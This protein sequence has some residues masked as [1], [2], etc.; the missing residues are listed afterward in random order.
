MIIQ[1]NILLKNHT[2]YKIGGPARYFIEAKSVAEVQ[3][4]LEFWKEKGIALFVLAGG[5]NILFS[6]GGFAGLVLK[7]SLDSVRLS[8]EE[9]IVEAGAKLSDVVEL[10]AKNGLKG[11]EW[12]G[13]LP[14]TIGGAVFGNAGAFGG[15]MKDI[16]VEVKSLDIRNPEK[17]VSRGN[18]E[19]GFGYRTSAF[20][21]IRNEIILE[22]KLRLQ[23]GDSEEI[24]KAIKEHIRYR[25]ER[26]PLEYPSAGS[27]FKNVDV[28]LVSEEQ[29]K[30]W[31]AV[32][33]TDPF[34]LVPVAHLFSEA[35]LKGKKVGGAMI[36][37]K[38]PNFFINTGGAT[39]SD[40]LDL[41]S[42]AKKTIKE[43][44]GIELEEEVQIIGENGGIKF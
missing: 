5:N 32:L 18:K 39:A 12:A 6:D 3:E 24:E 34:P 27:T 26:Q 10:A 21:Q 9:I 4:A 29:K 41:I 8:G 7:I 2:S 43:R 30:Q 42:S 25:I 14:G 15:E 22:I 38:H 31:S 19:C 17:I 36:S 40:V 13:G 28:N 35:G 20:K 33:K 16:V 11:I 1:E 44:F 23:Q 37:E